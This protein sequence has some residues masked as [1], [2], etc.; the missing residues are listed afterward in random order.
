MSEVVLEH[1]AA[2]GPAGAA[3]VGLAAL[4][5]SD[6]RRLAGLV[7]AGGGS[8]EARKRARGAMGR[9]FAADP[10]LDAAGW[11]AVIAELA[12]ALRELGDGALDAARPIGQVWVRKPMP[13]RL[14]RPR[15]AWRLTAQG[16]AIYDRCNPRLA[17]SE[18]RI[19]WF[20]VR[21]NVESPGRLRPVRPSEAK[22]EPLS[23]SEFEFLHKRGKSPFS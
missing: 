5:E 22:R 16:S 14:M 13:E 20:E 9:A 8:K 7:A 19:A 23:G 1:E 4:V 12:G 6:A 17:L 2:D 15:V 11:V 10:A 21:C 18:D 3:A